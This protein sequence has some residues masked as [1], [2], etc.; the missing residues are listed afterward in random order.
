MTNAE[1]ELERA[2]RH[3]LNQADKYVDEV[4]VRYEQLRSVEAA[5]DRYL[6]EAEDFATAL[7]RLRNAA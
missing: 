1:K 4:K 3:A 5:R 7:D 6:A 2:Y